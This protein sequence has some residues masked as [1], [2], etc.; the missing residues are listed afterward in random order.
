M[1][2][3]SHLFLL[4]LSGTFLFSCSTGPE[5]ERENPYDRDPESDSLGIVQF[6]PSY[7]NKYVF[8]GLGLKLNIYRNSHGFGTNTILRKNGYSEY[9][10]IDTVVV[11]PDNSKDFVEYFLDTE[12]S[13]AEDIGYPLIYGVKFNSTGQTSYVEIDFGSIE[14]VTESTTKEHLIVSWQDSVYLNNGFRVLR[15][16]NG[17]TFDFADIKLPK[18]SFSIPITKENL[19]SEY[20]ISP[21]K[22]L[23]GEKTFSDTTFYYP[24]SP[25][26]TNFNFKIIS[27]SKFKLT[28]KD[29]SKI[30]TGYKIID[31]TTDNVFDLPADQESIVIEEQLSPFETKDFTIL[32]MLNNRPSTPTSID[33]TLPDFPYPK[34]TNINHID[35]TSFEIHFED[36]V[37][38]E[39]QIYFNFGPNTSYEINNSK[40]FVLVTVPIGKKS[41]QVNF[42]ADL[43]N[44][45]YG[46]KSIPLSIRP[47]IELLSELKLESDSN[48]KTIDVRTIGKLLIFSTT[49]KI[50]SVDLS[51]LKSLSQPRLIASLPDNISLLRLSND[52]SIAFANTS[53]GQHYIVNTINGEKETLNGITDIVYDVSF[54]EDDTKIVISTNKGLMI[55][56]LESNQTSELDNFSQTA[57]LEFY[58]DAIRTRILALDRKNKALHYFHIDSQFEYTNTVPLN[59]NQINRYSSEVTNVSHLYSRN[60]VVGYKIGSGVEFEINDPDCS[61]DGFACI[62]QI[63]DYY[64]EWD[65]NAYFQIIDDYLRI[66]ST[67]NFLRIIS[68][69]NANNIHVIRRKPSK[70]SM[71]KINYNA[72]L[73]FEFHEDTNVLFFYD[74]SKKWNF[75]NYGVYFD[76]VWPSN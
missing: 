5:F 60:N 56:S 68:R 14:N 30:E 62:Y 16:N 66:V 44:G 69:S 35:D 73:L 33:T 41:L 64:Y 71:F 58:G 13:K 37:D 55:Y 15:K 22:Y 65:R 52:N 46:N 47:S 34:I 18:N 74:L 54:I 28:W 76:L 43:S 2:I 9:D 11:H 8:T 75:T 23:H 24:T 17:Q 49:N 10:I 27:D 20:L 57:E 42:S 19:S 39:R 48:S 21:Y 53:D 31:N 3:T 36:R 7:P 51:N 70:I 72:K 40:G 4:L 59:N 67:E 29:N 61:F 45:K 63:Y 26:P 6:P 32:A 50:Y 12:I 38:F 25:P 1:K